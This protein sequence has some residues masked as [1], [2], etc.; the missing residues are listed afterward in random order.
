MVL[1]FPKSMYKARLIM[2]IIIIISI[3]LYDTMEVSVKV[4]PRGQLKHASIL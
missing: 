3:A 1:A 2:I 4:I